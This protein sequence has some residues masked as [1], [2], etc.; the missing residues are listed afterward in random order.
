MAFLITMIPLVTWI[1][2]MLYCG[3]IKGRITVKSDEEEDK[4]EQYTWC[5]AETEQYTWCRAETEQVYIVQS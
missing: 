5:R 3:I 2:I 4:T 1:T